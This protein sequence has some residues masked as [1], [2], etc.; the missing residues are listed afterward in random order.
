MLGQL[1]IEGV[2][3]LGTIQRKRKQSINLFL[4][5]NGIAH[6][7]FL[8]FSIWIAMDRRGGGEDL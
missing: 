2:T 7:V 6:H 1:A 4:E 5:Q 8:N 3:T